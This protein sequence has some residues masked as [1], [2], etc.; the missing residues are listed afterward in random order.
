MDGSKPSW[1]GCSLRRSSGRW[2]MLAHVRWARVGSAPLLAAS[3]CTCWTLPVLVLLPSDLLMCWRREQGKLVS[4]HW[5][6]V[7]QPAGALSSFTAHRICKDHWNFC[8]LNAVFPRCYNCKSR[9]LLYQAA[10]SWSLLLQ[11]KRKSPWISSIKATGTSRLP[12]NSSSSHALAFKDA[13]TVLQ[14]R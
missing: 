12:C 4:G 14:H 13:V 1:E 3:S 5:C 10:L 11:Q 9:N 7:A 8:L 6:R 2:A